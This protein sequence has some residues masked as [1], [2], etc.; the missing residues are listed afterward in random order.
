MKPSLRSATCCSMMASASSATSQPRS[1]ARSIR[2]F[3]TCG[4]RPSIK[5]VSLSGL[6]SREAIGCI[7]D[8][9]ITDTDSKGFPDVA[10]Y[11]LIAGGT[12]KVT[13]KTH[14]IL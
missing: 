12:P 8:L 2:L 10:E 3:W 7:Y 11:L 9:Y 4:L 5:M 14:L 6:G 13:K 1:A